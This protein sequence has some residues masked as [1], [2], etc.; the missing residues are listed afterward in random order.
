M[1]DYE[2]VEKIKREL[3]LKLRE[4]RYNLDIKQDEMA[5]LLQVERRTVTRVENNF[6]CN[7]ET[8]IKFVSVL[9]LKIRLEV[10]DPT[11]VIE[12]EKQKLQKKLKVDTE[13]MNPSTMATKY[14]I[15]LLDKIEKE[16]KE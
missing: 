12:Y 4:E 10:N 3:C 15:D 1:L 7:F 9:G 11:D 6:K 13:N 2:E 14:V 16:I 8:F 5:D